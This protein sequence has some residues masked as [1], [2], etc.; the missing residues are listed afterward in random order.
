MTAFFVLC[1]VNSVNALAGEKQIEN[2]R[3]I[4]LPEKNGQFSVDKYTMGKSQLLGYVG[5]LKDT[6]H[7]TGVVLKRVGQ[8]TSEQKHLV[9]EIAQYWQIEAFADSGDELT[10]LSE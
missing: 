7:V 10:P 9:A 6:K 8:A 5:D 2:G 1:L 4:I 3:V